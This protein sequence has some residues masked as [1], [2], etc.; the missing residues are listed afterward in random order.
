MDNF[1]IFIKAERKS[2]IF[3]KIFAAVLLSMG[4]CGILGY[5]ITFVCNL[6]PQCSME[7]P[8]L[9]LRTK[10]YLD[11]KALYFF[12]LNFS[13]A[14]RFPFDETKFLGFE[15]GYLLCAYYTVSGVLIWIALDTFFLGACRYITAIFN[16]LNIYLKLS[17]EI[18]KNG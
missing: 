3:T 1:E 12:L 6:I 5:V 2:V 8:P 18:F 11:S 15:I 7:L 9:P 13:I 14:F 4:T 16:Y 10:L 17:D